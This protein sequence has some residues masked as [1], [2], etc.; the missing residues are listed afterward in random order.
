MN[1]AGK[2]VPGS[3]DGIKVIE[4]GTS[5]AAPY[6]A[7]ILGDFGAD[8]VKVERTGTGDD[9]RNWAPPEWEGYSVT[10]LALN[11][12][13]Q[14]V[15]IDYKTQQG[16]EVMERLIAGAD[17]L[18]QNLRPGSF[19][20]AGFSAE[21]LRELN[22]QLIYCEM[23]GYGRTGPRSQQPAYDPLLQA[24]SGIVSM[25]GDDGGAP[26]RVPVSVLDMG[27]G[28]W[29]ALA[30]FEALRRRDVTGEGSHVELS[31]LQ[32]AL[33]WLTP[34]LMACAA[35]DPPPRRLGSGF[36]GVVPYGAFPT[37]DGHVFMSAG[38]DDTWRRLILALECP[39]LDHLP[40]FG[41]NGD[42]VRNREIVVDTLSSRTSNFTS[43][44]VVERLT[45]ASVPHSPV[46]T[47]DKV[48]VDEQVQALGQ[49]QA[50]PEHA[51][52]DLKLVNLP[53]TFNGHYPE[54]TKAP[55]ELGQDT[56]S[57]L[58]SI[59]LDTAEI[60]ALLASGVV[61]A[62]KAAITQEVSI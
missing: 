41:S 43:A 10:F 23:S 9:S 38:N 37:K 19:A 24:Y 61:E 18:I 45:Q 2:N 47:V 62:G 3:L 11:R 49:I 54:I 31:L 22:P 27:T 44:E 13:K 12:N 17:V 32:T 7:Q 15:V 21:R 42:R 29:T 51:I 55:P 40:G 60:E 46:N 6:A 28:M 36:G 1:S 56:E 34:P 20:K 50:A 8:V 39:D 48:L 5:V 30:V 58:A 59:G 33:T 52:A 14:S 16:R 26:A 35:G 4:I 25:T 57:V 53:M